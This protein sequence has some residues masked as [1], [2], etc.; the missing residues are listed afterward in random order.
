MDP[1][2]FHL[3]PLTSELKNVFMWEIILFA[4]RKNIVLLVRD[5]DGEFGAP[6]IKNSSLFKMVGIFRYWKNSVLNVKLIFL[7]LSDF[8]GCDPGTIKKLFHFFVF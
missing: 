8:V 6:F 5:R 7:I 3:P 1:V 2:G 4:L